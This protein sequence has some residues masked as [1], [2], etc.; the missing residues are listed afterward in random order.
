MSTFFFVHIENTVAFNFRE[1]YKPL[2]PEIH[3]NISWQIQIL[4][5]LLCFNNEISFTLSSH[6]FLKR[7]GIDLILSH[8]YAKI[9]C[10]LGAMM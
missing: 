2:R 7:C 4:T 1:S 9:S 8:D 10:L 6:E 3:I 5:F